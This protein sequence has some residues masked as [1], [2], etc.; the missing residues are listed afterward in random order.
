MN[1]TPSHHATPLDVAHALARHAP[2][3]MASIL[4]PSVGSGVL[5]QPLIERLKKSAKKIVCIDSDANALSSVE[6]A[7]K[8]LFGSTLQL[9][10]DDFLKWSD[11]FSSNSAGL[12]DC[13][14]MNPP[15]QGRRDSLVKISLDDSCS[16]T[17]K[18]D[19]Y[20]PIEVAFVVRGLKLLKPGGRLLAIVPSSVV[21]S[22]ATNWIRKYLLSIGFV[23][24][25]HELPRFTFKNVEARVYL[26]VIEKG[27][28]QGNL[29][30]C[31]HD[32][33][34]PEKLTVPLS[35]LGKE[36]R[37]DYSFNH[38]MIWLQRLRSEFPSLGW[39]DVKTVASVYRGS[40]PS[41]QGPKNAIHTCDWNNGFW[42]SGNRKQDLNRS[43]GERCIKAGDL[44]VKRVGRAC[45]KSLGPISGHINHLC[46]DCIFLIRPKDSSS[47]NKLLFTLRV[48]LA[49][50]EGAPLVERGTGAAYLTEETLLDLP[51]PSKLHVKFRN[52][53]ESYR[54]ALR[55]KD[56]R[57]MR[58]I[59]NSVRMKLTTK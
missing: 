58:L 30:L 15:F 27:A 37:F 3:R 19:G 10:E 20:V 55:G 51:I 49:S 39:T 44:L 47:S 14:I 52:Q 54:K 23:R 31:N 46:S 33:Y 7:L 5:L 56:Q 43:S 25:V 34:K 36:T 1:Q 21:S 48:L 29:T 38:A 2:R 22:S 17:S 45:I 57:S 13:I 6:L 26:F 35:S 12:F 53:F 41:P 8:P 16:G 42:D 28:S 4:E 32:L 24:F 11:R 50:D 9:V 18:T 40:E 59:E